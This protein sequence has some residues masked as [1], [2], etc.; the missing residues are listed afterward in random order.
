MPNADRTIKARFLD[1]KEPNWEG[2][3]AARAVLGDWMTSKENPYF[4]KATANRVWEHFFGIGLVDPV[5]DMRDENPASHPAL[6]E[7]LAKAFADHGFDLKFLV[8]AITS[9]SAYQ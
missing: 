4:S 5:D 3:P 2:D 7:I 8:R 9:S 6:L 1:G